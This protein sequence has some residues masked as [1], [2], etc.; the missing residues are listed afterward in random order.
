MVGREGGQEAG[1]GGGGAGR[2]EMAGN[3]GPGMGGGG[4]FPVSPYFS[5]NLKFKSLYTF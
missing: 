5:Y 4:S 2:S 3:I 1:E